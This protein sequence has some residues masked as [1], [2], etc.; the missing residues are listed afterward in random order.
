MLSRKPRNGDIINW[1]VL[2]LF[3]EEFGRVCLLK[4]CDGTKDGYSSGCHS[5]ED[6]F[7]TKLELKF[8]GEGSG[9]NGAA[10]GG[11]AVTATH[12]LDFT[13]GAPCIRRRHLGHTNHWRSEGLLKAAVPESAQTL[14]PA[15]S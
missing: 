7:F 14:R 9:G 5:G 1:D 8:D 2:V 15:A 4:S 10:R 3:V 13:T 6:G 12:Y 11:G